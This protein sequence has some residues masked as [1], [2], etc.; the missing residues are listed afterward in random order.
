MNDAIR[1][2]AMGLIGVALLG[3]GAWFHVLPLVAGSSVLVLFGFAHLVGDIR[4]L[5]Q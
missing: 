2:S 5:L 3:V 1:S 4:R